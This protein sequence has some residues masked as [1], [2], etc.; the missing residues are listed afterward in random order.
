MDCLTNDCK[1][2]LFTRTHVYILSS[3]KNLKIV[4]IGH[5]DSINGLYKFDDTI[6]K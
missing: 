1:A 3:V 2:I 4:A 5:R 6:L